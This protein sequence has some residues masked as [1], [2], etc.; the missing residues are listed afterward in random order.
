MPNESRS[1]Q[2]IM[3]LH[4]ASKYAYNV[5]TLKYAFHDNLGYFFT[6]ERFLG[7][8]QVKNPLHGLPGCLGLK[9]VRWAIPNLF[10][11][12]TTF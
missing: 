5:S 9:H 3:V 4:F 2:G 10:Y 7:D 8:S 6:L 1:F 12:E 11:N